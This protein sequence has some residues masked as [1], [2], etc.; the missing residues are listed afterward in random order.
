M[1][2]IYMEY[3]S[4]SMNGIIGILFS[5]K[6]EQNSAIC[7]NMNGLG[8]YYT[9]W[10]KSDRERQILYDNHLYV[11]SIKQQTSENNGKEADSGKQRTNHW[12]PVGRGK[13]GGAT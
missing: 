6:K 10:N 12:L 4:Y 7:S 9:K 1:I 13:G 5:H 11:E 3:Y 2:Y 8:G